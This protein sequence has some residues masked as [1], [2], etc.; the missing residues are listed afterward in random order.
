MEKKTGSQRRRSWLLSNLGVILV[1]A[2]FVVLSV[3]FNR[4]TSAQN[5][6]YGKFR[7]MLQAEGVEFRNVKVGTKE[8]RG[9]IVTQDRVSDADGVETNSTKTFAFRTSRIGVDR[10]PALFDLLAAKAP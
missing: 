7:Q 10:D 8:I 6:P 1:V 4:D 5:I 2:L 3:L 9:E